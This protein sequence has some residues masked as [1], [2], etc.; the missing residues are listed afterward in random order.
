MDAFDKEVL[1]VAI[2][3]FIALAIWKGSREKWYVAAA[4]LLVVALMLKLSSEVPSPFDY[5]VWGA[6]FLVLGAGRALLLD[7]LPKWV[8]AAKAKDHVQAQAPEP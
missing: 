8:H 7:W 5:L 6:G 1:T 2:G 3:C 4:G